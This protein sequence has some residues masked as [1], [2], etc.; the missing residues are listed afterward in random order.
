ME[1]AAAKWMA[2]F[3]LQINSHLQDAN[4]KIADHTRTLCTFKQF[5]FVRP[6]G[7]GWL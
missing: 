5:L 3:K 2:G 6:P 4:C 1:R 7:V